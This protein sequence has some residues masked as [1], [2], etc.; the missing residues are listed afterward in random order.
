MDD[1]QE[2]EIAQGLREGRTTAWHALYDEYCQQVWG[3]VARRIGAESAD[4]A[5]VVQE[6]FL[7]AA[8]SAGSY[9]PCRGSLWM[10]LG[11]IARKQVALHF[12][13]QKRHDRIK[14]V[15]QQ[16]GVASEQLDRWLQGREELPAEALATAELAARV[17]VT[18]T[19][20][21]SD[22]EVLL[23]AKYCDG[24]TVDQIAQLHDSSSE[25]IR[26]K[27]ARARRAFRRAFARACTF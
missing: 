13:R 26:S 25:A 23:T 3:A 10:W 8:R 17:R 14:S 11:G 27:L 15:D 19:G 5:D 9:D 2:Q 1:R 4:V 20:L 16:P 6:T 18:L 24:A 21:P 7:A 12:R 22:Y